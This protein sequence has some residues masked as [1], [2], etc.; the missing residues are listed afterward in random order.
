MKVYTMTS[1]ESE[2]WILGGQAQVHVETQI[3]EYV[4]ARTTEDVLVRLDDG[5]FAYT[6][7]VQP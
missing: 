5:S 4:M 3:A 6:L 2:V 1:A 7:E